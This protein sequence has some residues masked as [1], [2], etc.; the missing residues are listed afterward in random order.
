MLVLYCVEMRVQRTVG[1][2]TGAAIGV[3]TELMD[4]EASLSIGI[5]TTEIPADGGRGVFIGLFESD[6]PG[7][8][9]VSSEDG[10][11]SSQC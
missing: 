3:V 5:M 6:V 10:N 4:V 1:T 2:S 9:G 7:D 8:L 11:Y